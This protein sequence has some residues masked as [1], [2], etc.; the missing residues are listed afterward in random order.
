MKFLFFSKKSIYYNTHPLKSLSLFSGEPAN[1]NG[2]KATEPMFISRSEAFRFT[3]GEVIS[4]P[5]EVTQ[6]GL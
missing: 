4:L 3:V 6:P 2:I 5:C 1:Q